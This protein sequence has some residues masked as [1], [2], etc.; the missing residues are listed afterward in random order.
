MKSAALRRKE[1]YARGLLA[2]Q[3]AIWYLRLKGYRIIRRRWRTPVGE[4]DLLASRGRTLVIV[5]VKHRATIA[6]ALDCVSRRQSQRLLHAMR[7]AVSV[8]PRYNTYSW[9]CDLIAL[10]PRHWPRHIVSAFELG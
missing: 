9:R 1:T 6:Q 5:E 8:L 2:E 4:I 10:A 7:Y 3:L